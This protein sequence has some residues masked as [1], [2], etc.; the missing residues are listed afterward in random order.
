MTLAVVALLV[1][2]AS[3]GDPA[4]AAPPPREDAAPPPA[5]PASPIVTPAP[6]ARPAQ[7]KPVPALPLASVQCLAGCVV[8]I[9]A[10]PLA[11]LCTVPVC[12]GAP[13]LVGYFETWIGDSFGA[14]RAPAKGPIAAAY[15]GAALSLVVGL[16]VGL[17]G[18]AS[19]WPQDLAVPTGLAAGGAVLVLA[20]AA[21]P[22][23]YH[24]TATPKHPL[25]DGSEPPDLLR[26]RVPL[27]VKNRER[28]AR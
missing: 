23:A 19:G 28:N 12:F 20:A 7:P 5:A 21:V 6:D 8:F 27:N 26:A 11:L 24:L 10:V 22:L 25:D 17:T 18:V 1:L 3:P 9:A 4:D 16:T 13:F 14:N 15:A 2:S